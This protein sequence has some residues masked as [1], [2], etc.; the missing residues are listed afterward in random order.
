M[1]KVYDEVL[2]SDYK[3]SEVRHF[4]QRLSIS[5]CLVRLEVRVPPR[6]RLTYR[7]R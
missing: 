4:L 7:R 2:L 1:H 3:L 6:P 5:A